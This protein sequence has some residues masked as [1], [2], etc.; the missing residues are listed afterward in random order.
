MRILIRFR[1]SNTALKDNMLIALEKFTFAKFRICDVLR[2][3]QILGS[4]Q[5]ITD[6]DPALF[7]SGFPDV[8]KK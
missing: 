3:I 8:N 2:R 7:V 6:P 1:I 5:W 4:V